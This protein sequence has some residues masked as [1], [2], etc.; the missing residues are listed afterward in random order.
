MVGLDGLDGEVVLVKVVVLVSGGQQGGE[1]GV[2]RLGTSPLEVV[3][4]GMG[5]GSGFQDVVRIGYDGF[6]LGNGVGT[7]ETGLPTRT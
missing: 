2:N 4:G 6:L 5:G 3:P 7:P 1:L